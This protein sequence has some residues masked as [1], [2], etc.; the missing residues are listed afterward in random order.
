MCLMPISADRAHFDKYL[1]INL[2]DLINALS[3]VHTISL[4]VNLECEQ[5]LKVLKDFLDPQTFIPLFLF[6]LIKVCLSTSV[7]PQL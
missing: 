5:I 1:A 7:F 2:Y 6:P 3:P 4:L